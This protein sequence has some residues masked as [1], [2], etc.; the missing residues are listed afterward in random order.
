MSASEVVFKNVSKRYPNGGAGIRNLSLEIQAG[1]FVSLVGPSGC[2]KSTTLNLVAGLEPITDG[3]LVMGGRVVNKLE[4][5]ERDVAM[6]F[7]S[8]ALYPHLDVR[9]NLT[10]PLRMAKLPRD[11]QEARVKAAASMLGLEKLLDRKPKELSGGQRQRV[12]LGRALVRRPGVF[13]FDEPLSNLDAN[14]RAQMRSEIKALHERLRITFLYVT[15]DQVEAMSLSTRIA[16]L[17]DGVL[18]QYGPPRELYDAPANTFVAQFFGAPPM[19]LLPPSSLGESGD[20]MLG[21]RPEDIELMSGSSHPETQAATV[22]WVEPLGSETHVTVESNGHRWTAKA[23][24]DFS[25]NVGSA[26]SLRLPKERVHRFS[27]SGERR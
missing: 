4:P 5:V 3:E 17:K 14:L 10:F 9:G 27:P 23:P 21:I 18:Q 8:Y 6:V 13:L 2:G 12:A 11:E 15:H 26:V 16:L 1:E 20:G 19:N 24:R 7:Q 22:V 25:G